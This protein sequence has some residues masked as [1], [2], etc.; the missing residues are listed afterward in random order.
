MDKFCCI[1]Q[2]P[3]FLVLLLERETGFAPAC[4]S[5]LAFS[6]PM[7]YSAYLLPHQHETLL[8]VSSPKFSI[9]T[10]ANFLHFPFYLKKSALSRVKKISLDNLAKKG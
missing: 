4:V 9:R 10:I 6:V 1:K 5:N 8:C 3:P 7:P 2:L